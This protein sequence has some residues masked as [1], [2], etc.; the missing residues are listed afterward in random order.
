MLSIRQLENELLAGAASG[1]LSYGGNLP[2]QDCIAYAGSTVKPQVSHGW[3]S[4]RD[5]NVSAWPHILI[6]SN[7]MADRKEDNINKH[8][9]S[10]AAHLWLLFESCRLV[11]TGIGPATLISPQQWVTPSKRS[12]S[13][14]APFCAIVALESCNWSN[15]GDGR[16]CIRPVYR[17]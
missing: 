12:I 15:S 1:G 17:G 16:K 9:V 11:S 6:A 8:V 7:G 14:N 13:Q 5:Q 3:T 10:H 2:I 4:A